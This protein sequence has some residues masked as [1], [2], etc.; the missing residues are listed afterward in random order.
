MH[1]QLQAGASSL[2][3]HVWGHRLTEPY[4]PSLSPHRY[5]ILPEEDH[6]LF[7]EK[8]ILGMLLLIHGGFQIKPR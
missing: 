2:A 8:I 5:F 7:Y 3:S 6:R 1:H 4:A